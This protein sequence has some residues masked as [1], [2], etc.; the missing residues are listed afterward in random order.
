MVRELTHD[1]FELADGE[2]APRLWPHVSNCDFDRSRIHPSTHP[3]TA[4]G[5]G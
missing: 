4:P 1:Q 5:W 3:C 2:L